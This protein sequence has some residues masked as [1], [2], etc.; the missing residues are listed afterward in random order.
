MKKLEDIPKKQVFEVPEGYFEKLPAIIQSRITTKTYDQSFFHAYKYRLQFVI[1]VVL[2][3][4]AGIFWFTQRDTTTGAEDL[5]AAVE[6]ADLVAYLSEADLTTDDLLNHV[7]LDNDDVIAIEE[8]VYEFELT[9]TDFEQ[10]L[11]EIEP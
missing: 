4:V 3:L 10:L 9:D 11:D 6:T 5:L 2:L 1:P 7:V 8:N